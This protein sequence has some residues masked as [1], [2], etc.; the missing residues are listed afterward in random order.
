MEQLAV[1]H[2]HRA[3][4]WE[5]RVGT[6]VIIWLFE[7]DGPLAAAADPLARG[8]IDLDTAACRTH[9]Q[10]ECELRNPGLERVDRGPARAEEEC[11]PVGVAAVGL[12]AEEQ[13]LPAG[14]A[15]VELSESARSSMPSLSRSARMRSST[16]RSGTLAK[17]SF[18]DGS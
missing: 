17:K 3:R 5:E 4:R 12:T 9:A 2:R 10:V 15:H 1:L 8:S 7:I 14:I 16:V 11:A 13:P 18:P 6:V